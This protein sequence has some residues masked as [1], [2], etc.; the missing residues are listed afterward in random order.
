[1]LYKTFAAL[2]FSG[3]PDLRSSVSYVLFLFD[4]SGALRTAGNAQRTLAEA[5][6]DVVSGSGEAAAGNER[7][8][9]TPAL[10]H[11]PGPSKKRRFE[12]G[13]LAFC[14]RTA[15]FD[16]NEVLCCS[17]NDSPFDSQFREPQ[18]RADTILRNLCEMGVTAD[19]P[20]LQG[21][22]AAETDRLLADPGSWLNG[23]I[24]QH[25]LSLDGGYLVC[26][27]DSNVT[28][29]ASTT[30]STRNS[31]LS[32]LSSNLS[33]FDTQF[34]CRGNNRTLQSHWLALCIP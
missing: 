15:T 33:S 19:P 10:Y 31:I 22:R 27:G 6:H 2:V 16:V 8:G 17:S 25:D 12:H 23:L 26:G 14:V 1:M 11:N 4:L 13:N 34:I 30:T 21:E 9:S 20:S 18:A 7:L 28:N 3:A 24:R 32:I 29:A 5:A